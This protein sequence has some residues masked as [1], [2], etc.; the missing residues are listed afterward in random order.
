M[1]TDETRIFVP[2]ERRKLAS[3]EVA[4]A[5]AKRLRPEWTPRK[6]LFP[7]SGQHKIFGGRRPVA[8]VIGQFPAVAERQMFDANCANFR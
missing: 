1:G 5:R 4:G 7:S 2:P 8:V 6:F 3:Y